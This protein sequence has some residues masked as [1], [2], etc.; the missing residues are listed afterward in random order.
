MSAAGERCLVQH[1]NDSDSLRTIAVEGLRPEVIPTEGLRAVVA[2]ALA[3]YHANGRVKAPSVAAIM[4]EPAFAD[5]LADA[6]ISLEY[7]PDDSIEWALD[8]LKSSYLHAQHTRF[9][10][11]LAKDMSESVG[12]AEKASTISKATDDLSRIQMAVERQD[13]A[14]DIR[15]GLGDRLTAYAARAADQGAVYGM[16]FG[17]PLIDTYTGGIHDGELAVMAA[18]PKVGKSYFLDAVALREWQSGRRVALYTLEN[19]VEMTLDRIACLAT[20]ISPRAW[21]QGTVPQSEVDQ[22]ETWIREMERAEHPLIIR[23]PPPGERGIGAIVRDAQ[24]RGAQSLFIDQ[25][26]FIEV[27]ESDARQPRHIQVRNITHELKALISSGRDRMPCLMAHQINREGVKAAHK[28][29]YYDM[30]DLA[31]SAE[32]ERT[33]DWVFGLYQSHDQRQ[34]LQALFQTM[35]VRRADVRH[36]AMVWNVDTGMILARAETTLEE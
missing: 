21:Q 3:Y 8:D 27:P 22:A 16:R 15:T 9:V 25:L 36:F 33:A 31:E 6:E 10:K 34:T 17:L 1:L 32:V 11:K 12:F 24:L 7:E 35:A 23:Q 2:F 28:R 13:Q 18:G 26:S 14:V 4:N 29:G 30:N 19:S 5:A 20:G